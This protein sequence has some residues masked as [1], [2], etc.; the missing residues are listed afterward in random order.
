MTI[1]FED[2]QKLDI[3]VGTVVEA[4]VPRWS[5]WVTKLVV[6]FGPEIGKKTVF[7]GIM[8]F[9]KAKDLVN[10]QF[11]F[12]VNVKPKK[13]GPKEE[14]GEQNFSEAMLLAATVPVE[15]KDYDE[16]PILLNVSQ[17]VENGARVQ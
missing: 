8:K 16:K 15:G 7:A 13:I 11:P 1:S 3:R 10:K 14:T 4:A 2:F 12:L 5:H 6:D 17:T 9:Y